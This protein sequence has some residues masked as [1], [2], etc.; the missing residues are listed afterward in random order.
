MDE[1]SRYKSMFKRL[2]KQLEGGHLTSDCQKCNS[3]VY[4]NKECT[5][6]YPMACA[7]PEDCPIK[8][9]NNETL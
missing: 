5:R 1:A 7:Y 3:P 9:L 4:E 6:D 8:K 2:S